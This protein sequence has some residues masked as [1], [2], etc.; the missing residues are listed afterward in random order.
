[1]TSS[2]KNKNYTKGILFKPK[3]KKIVFLG[4]CT[5]ENFHV[6]KKNVGSRTSSS[7]ISTRSRLVRPNLGP[8]KIPLLKT[9]EA[10]SN[11]SMPSEI[12]AII[13]QYKNLPTSLLPRTYRMKNQT[14]K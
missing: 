14:T 13:N 12:D 3:F 4:D 11:S 6:L 9:A 7:V 1:L 5:K 10:Q 8:S 2:N